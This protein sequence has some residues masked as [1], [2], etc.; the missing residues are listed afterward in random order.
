MFNKYTIAA[1]LTAAVTTGISFAEEQPLEPNTAARSN[2]PA[3]NIHEPTGVPMDDL[4]ASNARQRLASLVSNAVTPN[5]YGDFVGSLSREDRERLN[6]AKADTKQLNDEIN[7][8]R[9]AYKEKYGRDLEISEDHFRDLTFVQGQDKQHAFVTVRTQTAGIS[10]QGNPR[11][12]VRHPDQVIVSEKKADGTIVHEE[13]VE[14]S[15]VMNPDLAKKDGETPTQRDAR[16]ATEGQ[17][18]RSDGQPEKSQYEAKV[19]PDG[20]PGQQGVVTSDPS[21]MMPA[22]LTLVRED[23]QLNPWRVDAPNSLSTPQL[24]RNLS[25]ELSSLNNS[26]AA[27][28][29]D[30]NKAKRLIAIHV[31][32]AVQNSGAAL[33][34][35]E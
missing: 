4:A 3:R 16:V 33:S 6:A 22:R 34:Q 32:N 25:R 14:D 1:I 27:W 17:R 15:R 10:V 21:T 18:I 11:G 19:N 35:D 30:A 2:A 7:R 20:K 29:E 31:F 26:Q 24:E 23:M 12:D 28:P 9:T 13:R 8:L 5:S